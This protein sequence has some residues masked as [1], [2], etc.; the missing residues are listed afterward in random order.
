LPLVGCAYCGKDF[1]VKPFRI[2]RTKGKEL[3]CSKSCRKKLSFV[4]VSCLNCGEPF[5]IQA[6][7][8]KNGRRKFCSWKCRFEW[9]SLNIRG[10][11]SPSWRGGPEERICPI[12]GKAFIV[13]R[14]RINK[15]NAR[16]CSC[17]CRARSPEYQAQLKRLNDNG[18]YLKAWQ[19]QKKKPSKPEKRLDEILNKFFPQQWQYVGD[20]SFITEGIKLNPDFIHCDG[21]K[22]LI[23]VFGEYWHKQAPNIAWHRTE[24]GRMMV[25]GAIGFKCLVLWDYE[26]KRLLEPEIVARVKQFVGTD[27]E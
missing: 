3:C 19:S 27:I 23:E 25:Y 10:A 18:L 2:K 4:E 5:A 6:S 12:C 13:S 15:G 22:L 7:R 1:W 11:N 21:K 24:L 9:K 16:F 8:Y 14:A 17:A 26:I 20:G